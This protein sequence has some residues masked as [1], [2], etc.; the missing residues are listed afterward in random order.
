MLLGLGQTIGQTRSF[1][2]C[3]GEGSVLRTD[4]TFELRYRLWK[5]LLG[6]GQTLGQTRCFEVVWGPVLQRL[7]LIT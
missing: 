1:V 3:S 4:P 7:W 5:M 6:L 2:G